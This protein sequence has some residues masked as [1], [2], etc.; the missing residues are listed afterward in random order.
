MKIS[1][2]KRGFIKIIILIV[3][4]LLILSYFRIDLRGL[5]NSDSTQGNFSY[6]WSFIQQMW[7]NYVKTP[8]IFLLNGIL[9]LIQ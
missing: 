4:G 6:A 5:V 1:I 7:Y 9:H 8:V 3:V 2:Y